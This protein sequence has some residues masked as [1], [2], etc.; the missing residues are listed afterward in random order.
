MTKLFLTNNNNRFLDMRDLE[1]K[2]QEEL[3]S[4]LRVEYPDIY[5]L[6]FHPPNGG[7][8]NIQ[9]A[10]KLKKQGVKAGVPDIFVMTPR[11]GYHGLM[12]EFKASPPA[13]T[14][15]SDKQKEWLSR[16][17]DQGYLATVC[18]GVK[19]AQTEINNYMALPV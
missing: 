5:R 15:V 8:R 13:K 14:S 9:T 2:E 11:G 3:F 10:N 6:T 17:E 19:A 16:L 18:K 7:K 1:G 4:W 12:I